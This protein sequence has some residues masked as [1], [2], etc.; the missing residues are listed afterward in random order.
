MKCNYKIGAALA[1][2]AAAAV[3]LTACDPGPGEQAAATGSAEG[4]SPSTVQQIAGG[5]DLP[6]HGKA[7]DA[8]RYAAAMKAG[9]PYIYGIPDGPQSACHTGLVIPAGLSGAGEWIH[10]FGGAATVAGSPFTAGPGL[11]QYGCS[12]D[13]PP[14]EKPSDGTGYANPGDVARPDLQEKAAAEGRPFFYAM[15]SG[16]VAACHSAVRLP[17]GS[18]WVM[19]VSGEAPV[20]GIALS[21]T[22]NAYGCGSGVN[23]PRGGN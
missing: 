16:G 10:N 17:D 8:V 21:K 18:V 1:L 22:V 2:A 3:T 11:A 23:I 19:N 14:A 5:G 7:V 12:F 6:P 15:P 20:T 9:V 13:R 4:P